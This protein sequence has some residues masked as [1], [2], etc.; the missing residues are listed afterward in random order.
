[1]TIE[2]QHARTV[3][4]RPVMP[5]KQEAKIKVP[6]SEAYLA[7]L[8]ARDAKGIR[9]RF[10]RAHGAFTSYAGGEDANQARREQALAEREALAARALDLITA[11]PRTSAELREAFGMTENRMRHAMGMLRHQGLVQSKRQGPATVWERVG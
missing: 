7:E 10:S 1:M 11:R 6:L 4:S 2:P 8:M 3:C 9:A 5:P